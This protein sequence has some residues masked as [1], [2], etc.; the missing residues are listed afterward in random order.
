MPKHHL[1]GL[2]LSQCTK[3]WLNQSI[4]LD[5]IHCI[6]SGTAIIDCHDSIMNWITIEPSIQS[7]LIEYGTE[8]VGEFIE[9]LFKYKKLIQ[10]RLNQ[11]GML[12][13]YFATYHWIHHTRLTDWYRHRAINQMCPY[14]GSINDYQCIAMNATK[15]KEIDEYQLLCNECNKDW[16]MPFDPVWHHYEAS[17]WQSI[18]R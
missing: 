1:I 12:P 6:I 14:C 18:K 5:S 13:A 15:Q 8:S 10:P 11:S 4:S 9:H 2:S 7:Q 3:D 17:D 16:A